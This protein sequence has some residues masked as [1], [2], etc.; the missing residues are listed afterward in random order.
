V[1][2]AT[3]TLDGKLVVAGGQDGVLRVWNAADGK[4]VATFEPPK[5]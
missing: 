4:A 3:A 1:Y 2:A 5:D